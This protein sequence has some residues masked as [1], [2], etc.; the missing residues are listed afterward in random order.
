[1]DALRRFVGGFQ[2]QAQRAPRPQ[3]WPSPIIGGDESHIEMW[4]ISEKL[5]RILVR[6]ER[7]WFEPI[8]DEI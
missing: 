3:E 2:G 8:E 1:M 6:A 5:P 7:A 4:L